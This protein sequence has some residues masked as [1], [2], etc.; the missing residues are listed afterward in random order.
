M[1]LDIQEYW[2]N[3]ADFTP[4]SWASPL[5]EMGNCCL[6][7]LQPSFGFVLTGKTK[8]GHLDPCGKTLDSSNNKGQL[9]WVPWG[10]IKRGFFEIRR[11]SLMNFPS[12]PP[13]GIFQQAAVDYQRPEGRFTSKYQQ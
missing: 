2:M 11:N 10:F 5:Y 13:S 9:K 3:Q 8:E 12:T 7:C 4:I 6:M 1:F